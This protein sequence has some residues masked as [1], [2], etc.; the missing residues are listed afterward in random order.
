MIETQKIL[1]DIYDEIDFDLNKICN[2]AWYPRLMKHVR[3]LDIFQ[4]EANEMVSGLR[5]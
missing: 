3:L 4:H 2:Q 1:N 5:N